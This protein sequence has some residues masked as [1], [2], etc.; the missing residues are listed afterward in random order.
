ME[1]A[2]TTNKMNHLVDPNLHIWGWEVPVYL[3]LG[4]ITAGILIVVSFMLLKDKGEKSHVVT[5]R[6][7]LLA[8]VLLS[9]GMVALFLDLEHKFYVWRFYTAF[10]FTSPMSWGSWILLLVYPISLLLILTTFRDGF[11]KASL[12]I[13]AHIQSKSGMWKYLRA[14]SWLLDFS[15][16]HRRLIARTAILFGILLGIYT[17]IL[18]STFG[19]RP[20]WNSS[21]IGPIFLVS[22]VSTAVALVV[23]FSKENEEIEFF[24]RIDI[25]LIAG[26]ISLFIL[27]I[28]GMLSSS[29]Q[30]LKAIQLILGGEM[31]TYFWVF[32][33]GIGLL[34]PAFLEFMELKGRKIPGIIA[35]S[36]VLFGGIL[37][38][39]IIVEAGQI[40]TW[41]S[42]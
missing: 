6:L 37:L 26:E 33:F 22:G 21:I 27:F 35:A 24:T 39:F 4:G 14:Y 5:N 10:R 36:L 1:V 32:F 23:L 42:Y 29:E 20:F 41:I 13:D 17:G 11:S 15:E 7:A 3:F 9:L 40:S 30:H 18:L 16:K 28:I 38:R 34:L 31:T 19:A 2:I 25:W 8:P 12:W